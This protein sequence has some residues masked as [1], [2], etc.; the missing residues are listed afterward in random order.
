MAVIAQ[1]PAQNQVVFIHKSTSNKS[2]L[3]MHY[4]LKERGIKNNDFFLVLRDSGLAGVDP[5]DPNLPPNMK[6]RILQECRTNYWYYLREILRIPI[7]GGATE[8]GV[9]YRL[10]RASLAMNFLFCLNFSMYVELPRQFGKTTTALARYL[11]VYNFGTS[12][13][14]I[15]FMHKDHSGSKDNLKTLRSYRD[16][17]PSYLQLSSNIGAD[18]KK[19][20]VPNTIVMMQ[21]PFNNNRITTKPSARTKEAA[22]NLGRGSTIP[23]QYYDEFAFM[24]FNEE[25]L[26]AAGPAYSRAAENARMMGAPYGMLITSTPGDLL[27]GPG[28]YAYEVRNNATV[29]REEYYDM[30]YEQLLGLKAANTK[31][32]RFLVRFDYKQL[33]KGQAYL[34]EMIKILESNW[35]KIRREVLLEWAE[36]PTECPFTQDDLE[37]IKS[38]TRN[39]IRTISFGKYGQY[40]FDVYKDIDLLYPPIIGV[41]VSGATFNDS[42]AITIIDSHTTEVCACMNCN[43]IPNDDLAQVIYELIV[44]YMPN[45]ICNI[46]LNGENSSYIEKYQYNYDILIVVAKTTA[47]KVTYM[48]SRVNCFERGLNLAA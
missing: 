32:D 45:A 47:Y 38:H 18:G 14:E 43:F 10:D 26:M 1:L 23:L 6:L 37:I 12:N 25:V 36:S 9:R 19:L 46:E 24:P 5:R 33:G 16:A 34:N 44:N 29:W 17:L 7:Q 21:H 8:G 39:P 13:S 3:D 22:N 4:F 30:T 41:D 15:M 42:S 48:T 35:P 28:T 31:S 2:F 40:V 20:K 11:W 27:T